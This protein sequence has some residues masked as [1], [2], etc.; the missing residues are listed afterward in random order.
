MKRR[1]LAGAVLL[2]ATAAGAP[3]H[4]AYLYNW[5]T[6]Q[7][8]ADAS[9]PHLFPGQDILGAYH[10][11]DGTYHYF[12]MDIAAQ[13]SS[14]NGWK[15][16]YGIYIDSAPGGANGLDS[17]MRYVPVTLNG[18]DYVIDSH[19]QPEFGGWFKG[20]YHRWDGTTFQLDPT[21]LMAQQQTENGGTTLEWK[22]AADQIG[23]TFAWRA[24]T[25]DLGYDVVTSDMTGAVNVDI[26]NNSGEE[27]PVPV[28]AAVYLLGSGL[29]GLAGLKRK[30]RI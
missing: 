22:V 14:L 17:T 4:A 27:N 5:A 26:N 12:R 11:Y 15:G 7:Y 16:L 2:A 1:L 19:F 3:A 30:N 24:V 25:H 23:T 6:A 29:I 9:D 10:G 18:I 8:V 28:P 13:P 21:R 20:D